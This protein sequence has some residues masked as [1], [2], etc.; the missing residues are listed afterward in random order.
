MSGVY[1]PGVLG[2]WDVTRLPGV[3]GGLHQQRM[4]AQGRQVPDTKLSARGS[5]HKGKQSG[6]AKAW[7]PDN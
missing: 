7:H 5:S 6:R 4:D 3:V 1:S 2:V